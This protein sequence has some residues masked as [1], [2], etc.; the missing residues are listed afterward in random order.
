MNL[1]EILLFILL[2]PILLIAWII[3]YAYYRLSLLVGRIKLFF[4]YDFKNI[5][6]GI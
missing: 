2:Y 3:S 4:T 5:Q 6:K 1:F